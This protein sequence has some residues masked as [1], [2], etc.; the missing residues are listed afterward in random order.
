VIRYVSLQDRRDGQVERLP[1]R[2][3]GVN[4]GAVDIPEDQPVLFGFAP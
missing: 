4:Q 3:P 2:R 1:S